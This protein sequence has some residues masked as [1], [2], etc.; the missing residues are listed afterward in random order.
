VATYNFGGGPLAGDGDSGERG[1]SQHKTRKQVSWCMRRDE[2]A[3]GP[4]G[5]CKGP[6]RHNTVNKRDEGWL[7]G[8]QAVDWSASGRACSSV[9]VTVVVVVVTRIQPTQCE[10]ASAVPCT[11]CAPA[12]CQVMEEI[13]AKSKMYKALKAK[14]KEEDEQELDKVSNCSCGGEDMRCH[15]GCNDAGWNHLSQ[16]P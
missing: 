2:G 12:P 4:S 6:L 9:T 10:L 7:A 14:Q 3:E 8:R 15:A 11:C 16:I 13:I 5:P 1:D